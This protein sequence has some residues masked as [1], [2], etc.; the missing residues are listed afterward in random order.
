MH[1]LDIVHR[2]IKLENILLVGGAKINTKLVDFGFSAY[3]KNSRLH[4]FCG[5]DI[6]ILACMY[7]HLTQRTTL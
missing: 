3:V 5:K 6:P 4:V 7:F 1:G 2:D